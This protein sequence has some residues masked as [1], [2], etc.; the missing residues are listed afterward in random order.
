M[1]SLWL[2]ELVFSILLQNPEEVGSHASEGT[3]VPV[4][5]GGQA[6]K[7]SLLLLCP[8]DRLQAEDV[9]YIKAGSSQKKR[10][11]LKVGL[12]MVQFG[13]KNLSQVYPSH[14]GFS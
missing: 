12:P 10:S 5:W 2:S 11:R 9:T 7:A 3:D 14:V 1:L 6:G 8:L 13:K 4:G